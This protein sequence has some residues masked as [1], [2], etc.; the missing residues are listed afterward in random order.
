MSPRGLTL[1]LVAAFAMSC[2]GGPAPKK[3]TERKSGGGLADALA[4]KAAEA[5]GPKAVITLALFSTEAAPDDADKAA[6][7]MTLKAAQWLKAPSGRWQG[8]APEGIPPE[9]MV[10]PMDKSALPFNVEALMAEAGPHAK[11]LA[12][13]RSVIFVRY[14]GKALDGDA[15][16][17]GVSAVAGMLAD[18]HTAPVTDLSTLKTFG[19][20]AWHTV[21]TSG[22]WRK[23]QVHVSAELGPDGL[24]MFRTRGMAKFALPDLERGGIPEEKARVAFTQFQAIYQALVAHGPAA[25]GD[26][27]GGVKLKACAG[28]AELYDQGCVSY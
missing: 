1:A 24:G 13:A 25:P 2:G 12:E 3:T 11:S 15:Q 21:L 17:K 18:A 19:A 5:A 4:E 23:V 16:V 26:T 27:V 14:T 10:I 9:I 6:R 22:D 8:V 20:D 28:P 7:A